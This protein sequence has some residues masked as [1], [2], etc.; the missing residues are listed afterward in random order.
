MTDRRSFLGTLAAGRLAYGA[1]ADRKLKLG[2]IGAGW[3]GMV[4][5]KAAYDAGGVE[6]AAVCDID[7]GHLEAAAA[8]VEKRQ[9]SRPKL[10]KD[11]R[12]L[13][14]MPGLDALIVATP[15][16]W[17]AL[18]FI[19]ACR[20]GLAVYQEKPLAYDVREVQAMA[21]AQKK[22]G[23]I[24]QVGF[25]RRRSDAYHEAARCVREGGI[26][27]LVQVEAQIH[28]RAADPDTTVKDPPPGLD[29]ETWC[30]PSP[31]LPYRESIGHRRWRLEKTTGHG[32]LVDW[33]I[34]LVDA[35]RMMTG[36]GMPRVVQAMGGLY[37]YKGKIT[38]PDTL[39]A[40]FEFEK[41][42]LV[43][44]HRL[45][46]SV[47]YAPE[48]NNGVMLFGEKGS[49]FVTDDRWELLP[50][51]KG[52]QKKVTPAKTKGGALGTEH[53][54]DFLDA[55]RAGRQPACPLEDGAMSTVAVQLAMIAYE[56]ASRVEWDP[57]RWEI[58]GNPAAARLLK[59]EYRKPW[60]HPYKG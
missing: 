44:R 13:I 4:D 50:P 22:A 36:E 27:R 3:Y 14:A 45:W 20:K 17:H 31:K 6:C 49:I 33:G 40:Q 46:G 51:G 24:V 53:M 52:A 18:Q 43:W 48:S 29:W 37:S 39:T 55:V 35:V 7:A 42:P 38:T 8:E 9:G 23:N 34:H 56:S 58:Q 11:Y 2:V 26:G 5:L 12:E 57:V 10:F 28:F 59:R 60:V 16:H 1:A 30:G 19:D 32:H 41:F 47:E 25:Q 15:P 21:A 54:R